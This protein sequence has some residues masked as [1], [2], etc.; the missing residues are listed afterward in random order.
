MN[1]TQTEKELMNDMLTL[2]K[3]S[4]YQNEWV[5][6]YKF[7]QHF[8]KYCGQN[9]DACLKNKKDPPDYLLKIGGINIGLEV[10]T[11][12]KNEIF[13]GKKYWED[14]NQIGNKIIEKHKSLL[15]SGIYSIKITPIRGI[16]KLEKALEKN[17]PDLFHRLE[18][19]VSAEIELKTNITSSGNGKI[20]IC[21]IGNSEKVLY[22]LGFMIFNTLFNSEN[23]EF[24]NFTDYLQKVI[25]K[26]EIEYNKSTS[27]FQFFKGEKWLLVADVHFEMNTHNIV[28]DISSISIKSSLFDKIFFIQDI[29]TKYKISEL[30]IVK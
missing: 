3:D 13:E 5:P 6:V 18:K 20:Q 17:I 25:T 23:W 1:R 8:E 26:K 30:R 22:E 19:K 4:K 12:T 2:Q 28:F 27:K 11:F 7:C 29:S 14:I 10:T 15:S 16:K 21:K 9:I 24:Q